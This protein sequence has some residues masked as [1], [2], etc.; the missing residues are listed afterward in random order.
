MG[1][2]FVQPTGQRDVNGAVR[3]RPSGVSAPRALFLVRTYCLER[4][5]QRDRRE[6]LIGHSI[7]VEPG[8][9][10]NNRFSG[11]IPTQLGQLASLIVVDLNNNDLRGLLPT[12]LGLI[13]NLRR[14][15]LSFNQLS[16]PWSIEV[17][18]IS[19]T[20]SALDLS[21]NGFIGRLGSELGQITQLNYLDL[22][23]LQM[24]GTIPTELGLLSQLSYLSLNGMS[25][26]TGSI[27]TEFGRLTRLQSLGLCLLNGSMPTELGLLSRSSRVLTCYCNRVNFPPTYLV[28]NPTR[29]LWNCVL[30]VG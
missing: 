6:H 17:G 13:P 1:R 25:T 22:S 15:I 23:S 18:N 14:R 4:N 19:S 8:T 29:G 21:H 7:L 11:T 27:P 30:A 3:Q 20:L 5:D 24:G 10:G 9:F 16:G 28:T 12:Q 26:L 2:G